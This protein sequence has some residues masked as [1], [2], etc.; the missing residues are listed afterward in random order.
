[1]CGEEN[2]MKQ[3]SLQYKIAIWLTMGLLVVDPLVMPFSYAEHPIEVDRQAP[4]DRQAQVTQAAN[5]VTLVN[6]TGPTAGGVSRND[7][8]KFNV[9]ESG[10]ILNNSYGMSNTVLAGYV[11]GNA[12]MARGAARVILNEVTSTNPTAMKGFLEVAG[13]KA[14]VVVANPNG[15]SVDGGGFINTDRAVLTTGK[16]ELTADGNIQTYRVE[17]GAV[18]VNGKGLN[19]K[20]ANALQILTE[21]AH[22]NAGVWANEADIRTGKNVVDANTLDTQR[23][24]TSNQVGLDVAAIGGMY[25]NAI[26][27]KGSNTGLG[28]NVKGVV[29]AAKATNITSDGRIVVSGGVTSNGNTAISG[30]AV[31]V[32][33]SGIIQGDSNATVESQTTVDNAGLIN[34]GDTTRVQASTVDNHAGGRVYGDVVSIKANQVNNHTNREL[35]VRYHTAGDA[36]KAAKKALDD[37]WNADITGYKT[38]EELEAH[39]QRIQNLTKAYDDAQIQ[40]NTIETEFATHKSATIAGRKAVD[41]EAKHVT[42]EGRGLIYSVGSMR[43]TAKKDLTNTGATIKS[44]GAMTI[45]APVVKNENAAFGAKRVSD[46]VTKNPDK[47]KVNDP[48]H[49]L[50][51]QVFDKSEFPYADDSS[52]YGTPRVIP[53]HSE[54]DEAYN[55]E[56][57][58]GENRVHKFTI[59]RSQTEHTHTDITHDDPGVISSGGDMTVSGAIHNTNSRIVAGGTVHTSG[60]IDNQSDEVSEKTIS[61]G[62]TQES[63]TRRVRKSHGIGHKRRRAWNAEVFMTPSITEQNVKP[64]GVIKDHAEDVLSTS[65]IA[66]VNDSL[67]PYGLGKGNGKR[68]GMIDG[69]SL[70]TESLYRIHPEITANALVETDPAFTDRKQFLSSQYMID[71]L[72][73]DP[74]RRLKRLGDGFYEQQLVN[75]QILAAT[76]RQYLTGY[77]DNEV[78]YK[79]LLEAGIAYGKQFNLTPGITLSDAQMQAITTDMVW[80]ETKTMV[81]NGKEQQVLYPK[82]YLAKQSAKSL[83]AMG[84]LIS[85]YA[86]VSETDADIQ[87]QGVMTADTIVLNGQNI[88][89]TGTIDG[90]TVA[91]AAKQDVNTTGAIHGDTH[92]VVRAGRDVNVGARVKALSNQD[93]VRRQGTVGVSE[94]GGQLSI[95]AN[96]DI[97]L[98]GALVHGGANTTM[99][100]TAGHDV[101]LGTEQLAAKKDMTVNSD[102]YNRTERRTELGTTV[103]GDGDVAIR[104]GHD[105]SVRNGVVNSE[106]GTTTMAA[107]HDVNVTPGESYSRDE[108]GIKYKEKSLLSKTVRTLRTDHEH[109]GVLSSTIGGNAV[110]MKA[111]HDVSLTGANVL[112]TKDVNITAGHDVRTDS[113]EERQRDDIYENSKKTGLMSAGIGFTIGSKKVTDTMD[114]KYTN[115]VETNIASSKGNIA[116]N[117]GNSIHSTATNYFSNQPAEL[118]AFDVTIDGKHNV[119]HEVQSHEEKRSGLTV[120][121]GGSVVSSLNTAQQLGKKAH[122]RQSSALAAFEYGELANAAKHAYNDVKAYKSLKPLRLLDNEKAVLDSAAERN[123]SYR[124]ATHDFDGIDPAVEKVQNKQNAYKAQQAKHDRLFNIKVGIGS[125]QYKQTS[126]LDQAQYVGSSIGSNAKVTV[127]GTGETPNTGNVHITGSTID[128]PEVHI[129]AKNNIR[130]DAGTNTSIQT[131]NY[132]QSGWSVGATISPHGNG[133]IGLDANVFNGKEKGVETITTHGSTV[134]RGRQLATTTSGNNTDILGSKITGN[135][136]VTN[137]GNDLRI[138][139]LQDTHDYH[140]NSRN[141]SLSVSYGM[142]GPALVGFENGK[143]TTDSHYASVTDQAGIYADEGG[144]HVQVGNATTLTGSIIKGSPDKSKNKLS[145]KSLEMKDIQNDASYSAKTSGYSL[146]TT[147][148][149]KNN[150]LGITGSPNMGIP[151]KDSAKS[152]THSAISEGIIELAEKESLEKINHDTEHALNKLAPIFDKKKVEEKQILLT[153][154]SNQGYKLIGDIAVSQQKKYISLA[155]AA[156]ARNDDILAQKYRDKAKQWDEGGIYKITLHGVFGATIS[157]MAGGNIKQG[158]TTATLNEMM[159]KALSNELKK[160]GEQ[161]E[162]IDMSD[163]QKLSSFILGKAVS[164]SQLGASIA[165]SATENNYLTHVQEKQYRLE[166]KKAQTAEEKALVIAKWKKIDDQQEK[167]YNEELKRIW[168]KY[169]TTISDYVDFNKF[170]AYKRERKAYERGLDHS[171]TLDN[172]TGEIKLHDINVGAVQLKGGESLSEQIKFEINA[173]NL[174]AAEK[175]SR[176]EGY[177]EGT[178]EFDENVLYHFNRFSVSQRNAWSNIIKGADVSSGV[179]DTFSSDV[180]S[181]FK[182]SIGIEPRYNKYYYGGRVLG[183]SLGIVGGTGITI[184]GAAETGVLTVGSVPTL[185]GSSALIPASVAQTAAGI[186]LV[187]KSASQI[188]N[189]IALFSKSNRNTSSEKPKLQRDEDAPYIKENRVPLDSETILSNGEYERTNKSF[190]GA[191]IYKKDEHYYYRDTKHFGRAAE[192]EVFDKNGNHIGTMDPQTGEM[193]F[194]NKVSGRKLDKNLR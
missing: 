53:V 10:T 1:M 43:V 117:A 155:E 106:Q 135:T 108:Y 77:S 166:L 129:N 149:T 194:S 75:Q 49:K 28:V 45:D 33:K 141:K 184:S 185:G 11:P 83:D 111:N 123:I 134:I 36:L 170:L 57:N 105:V 60:A 162:Y 168:S 85:G 18:S 165:V 81:V 39:K 119:T 21:A 54:K 71:A 4:Q 126:E 58:K 69:L 19:A 109:T 128:A 62:T 24:G 13:Q 193:N 63:Y 125:S 100:I 93:V 84:G 173:M 159:T 79:A 182:Q 82:V 191:A 137:A 188:G 50:E 103:L 127:T 88:H 41:V 74:E 161:G 66:K 151:V 140:K 59:I 189:D 107:G 176:L 40:L 9:P 101:K 89:N 55:K 34:S 86:I 174:S 95:S 92:V 2:C 61:T 46:G 98:K 72:N 163:V 115:Q 178:D 116:V 190:K 20:G 122:N 192:I 64:I 87:N 94:P 124:L 118:T 78:E 97:H 30:Q 153:K 133:V 23:I 37:E 73:Q 26:T 120:S 167:K 157:N 136:V 113:G 148:R 180:F 147:K 32:G 51:G 6:V 14:S 35:E 158:F 138:E 150:P 5:G 3:K 52:G 177:K 144:Y 145:S 68:S 48:N 156:D 8:T 181:S 171:F 114:G 91:V 80:L 65:T 132:T 146:S 160:H 70:P 27:M 175:I 31:T 67:D 96:R 56:M 152:T 17:Q 154:I 104:A 15:I 169:F 42:N 139:S 7:Y 44:A 47:L 187:N 179:I 38:Q 130:L 183:D 143:G 142:S 172:S 102:N 131:N 164:G 121:V 76:G 16:P 186:S 25:A 90:R 22:I 12:N 110:D 99:D 112:G 29:S